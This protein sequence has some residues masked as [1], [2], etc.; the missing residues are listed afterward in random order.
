MCYC[1]LPSRTR[2]SDTGGMNIFPVA[3]G[4]VLGAIED[5][6]PLPDDSPPGKVSQLQIQRVPVD[7]SSNIGAP[8]SRKHYSQ[9]NRNTSTSLHTEYSKSYAKDVSSDSG[10]SGLSNDC[11][12]NQASSPGIRTLTRMPQ[13]ASPRPKKRRHRGRHR[14]HSNAVVIGSLQDDPSPRTAANGSATLPTTVPPAGSLRDSDPDGFSK[15]APDSWS[16]MG[17]VSDPMSWSLESS[18]T[19]TVPLTSPVT[20]DSPPNT[21]C[22]CI[23]PNDQRRLTKGSWYTQALPFFSISLG[24]DDDITE[25]QCTLLNGVVFRRSVRTWF[26]SRS[27]STGRFDFSWISSVLQVNTWIA[28]RNW[29]ATPSCAF[30]ST[31]P[32]SAYCGAYSLILFNAK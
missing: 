32:C 19:E 17:M 23:P 27:S 11:G 28:L 24:G 21:A 22:T 5:P 15:S 4:D 7:S 31:A 29:V 10:E 9:N 25:V 30:L 1:H 14:H 26:E 16:F 2:L 12:N 8:A 20:E 18:S 6:P 13:L 3:I